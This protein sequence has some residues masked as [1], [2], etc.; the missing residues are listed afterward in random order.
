MYKVII[1]DDEKAAIE[2]LRRDL[3]VQADLEIKGT[4]GNGAKGKKLIMDIHPD[5]LFLDIE[6]P[7]IQGIRLLSEI[8]EQ[9]L[10]DMKVVFYTAYDKY[11]LQ[12]LRES[13]FD[14]LLKPYDIE[15][16]NL[17]IERYRKTMASAQPL[18][19]FAS[20]VG[21]LM[22]GRDLF[23]ISTVTGFRFLRLEEIG[24]FEYLKDKRLWQV[25]LFNQT[26]L[27]LKKNTTA[28]DIIG[29]SDA[30]V[31]ISQSAIININYLA[32]IKSK[33]CLL[34]PPFSDKEDLIIS[35]GF[36]KELQECFCI[37]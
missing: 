16:L 17:I 36:L 1:I 18:P 8:R 21:T 6:L 11:L 28:G 29:Y 19:S 23:M 3:E 20:A 22:P 30:F 15:E 32:M 7:D 37:I 24:Y 4:A 5:L 25:E 31:Q 35:R 33:Q 12:A 13:A 9:V 10:W 2:T 14:Y 34:Y 26:K 27:C